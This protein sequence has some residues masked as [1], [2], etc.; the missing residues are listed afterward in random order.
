PI[1]ESDFVHVV[2]FGLND[3]SVFVT[4]FHKD[5]ASSIDPGSARQVLTLDKSQTLFGPVSRHGGNGAC[6]GLVH[7]LLH[8]VSLRWSLWSPSPVLGMGS[9]FPG[10]INGS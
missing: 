9:G 6:N 8:D 5:L 1:I 3:K 2:K 10:R 7:L 4:F